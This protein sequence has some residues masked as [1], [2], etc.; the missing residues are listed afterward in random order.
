MLNENFTTTNGEFRC[1]IYFEDHSY[2]GIVSQIENLV[3]YDFGFAVRSTFINGKPYF[4]AVD[5]CKGLAL[6]TDHTTHHVMQAVNDVLVYYNMD[7]Q[8]SVYDNSEHTTLP[9][10][11]AKMPIFVGPDANLYYYLDINTYHS[12]GY[13]T[14]SQTVRTLFISEP[15]LYMLTFRSTKREAIN[16]KAWLSV[17]ILPKLRY[18][19]K[20]RAL[21]ALQLEVNNKASE[22]IKQLR[23]EF[24]EFK[25]DTTKRLDAQDKFSN[26]EIDYIANRF[27]DMVYRVDT[28]GYMTD[29]I[30]NI[31]T[32][33]AKNTQQIANGLHKIFGV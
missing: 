11:G 13:T 15:V 17:E 25:S 27:N 33:T 24:A 32:D 16:F 22:E 3:N 26:E 31:T 2:G 12:N 10:G 20:E 30:S 19:G 28:I 4:A 9:L 6:S 8:N 7:Q 21:Q 29:A 23:S 5:I 1:P 14:V 18:L